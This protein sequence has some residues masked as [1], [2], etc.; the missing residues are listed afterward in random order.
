MPPI[1]SLDPKEVASLYRKMMEGE[2]STASVEKVALYYARRGIKNP[3]THR[4]YTRQGIW[5]AL[6]R[7]PEGRELIQ[8]NAARISSLHQEKKGLLGS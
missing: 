3:K 7:T 4:A 2:D 6:K 1:E 8:K 5:L